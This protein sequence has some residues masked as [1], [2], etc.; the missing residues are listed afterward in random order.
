VSV[1]N[2][3]WL[4]QGRRRLADRRSC[5]N[6]AK[7]TETAGI[8]GEALKTAWPPAG[9]GQANEA[10]LRFIAEPAGIAARRS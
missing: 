3:V 1:S 5:G 4:P 9:G 6:R 10:L 8:H 7:R 2:P